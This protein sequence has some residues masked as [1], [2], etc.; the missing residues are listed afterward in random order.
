[1]PIGPGS[2]KKIPVE[3]IEP[4]GAGFFRSGKGFLVRQRPT[5][6]VP[7]PI[8]V[9]GP[10]GGKP[11]TLTA[12][13]YTGRSAV[14]RKSVVIS[15]DGDRM[16]YVAKGWRAQGRTI[17]PGGEVDD[18]SRRSTRADRRSSPVERGRPIPVHLHTGAEEDSRSRRSAGAR[19]RPTRA[20]E[21]AHARGLHRSR[22]T[23]EASYIARDG[24][25]YAYNY[26]RSLDSNLY[27]SMA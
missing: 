5:V 12:E 3:G 10:E 26:I 6:R 16:A 2:P 25:S 18:G 9:R 17:A 21:E 27:L 20:L 19:D 13:G 11:L 7:S 22:L 23:R 1:M 15:P 4:R 24:Q 8:L 14:S